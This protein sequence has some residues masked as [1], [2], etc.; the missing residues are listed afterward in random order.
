[1]SG[2]TSG[3]WNVPWNAAPAAASAAAHEQGEHDARQAH[4]E[5]QRL[6]LGGPERLDGHYLARQH[7]PGLGRRDGEAAEH[8]RGERRDHHEH[9]ERH[10]DDGRAAS[11]VA[12]GAPGGVGIVAGGFARGVA[13]GVAGG[14]VRAPRGCPLGASDASSIRGALIPPEGL[15]KSPD[16]SRPL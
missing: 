12:R 9:A 2:E 15:L 6:L 1:M 4:L 3:F 5:E 13:R 14:F 8:E 11:L 10:E 16:R 7:A